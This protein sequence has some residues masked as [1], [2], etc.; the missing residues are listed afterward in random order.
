MNKYTRKQINLNAEL[1]NK[2]FVVYED[3]ENDI[4]DLVSMAIKCGADE[5]K[6]LEYFS[7]EDKK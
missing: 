6:L 4:T 7:D 1:H 3:L 2:K 5:D